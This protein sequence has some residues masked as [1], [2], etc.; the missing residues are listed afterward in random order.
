MLSLSS[1]FQ[2]KGIFIECGFSKFEIKAYFCPLFPFSP[3]PSDC[4]ILFPEK[5]LPSTLISCLLSLPTLTFL[6]HDFGLSK[7]S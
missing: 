3:L 5:V 7:W 1:V 2:L 6:P 4:I